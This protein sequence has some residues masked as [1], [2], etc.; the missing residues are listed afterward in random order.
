MWVWLYL[1]TTGCWHGKARVCLPRCL[2]NY[3]RCQVLEGLCEI[4]GAGATLCM[5][6][7]LCVQ[8]SSTGVTVP[9]CL[10][11]GIARPLCLWMLARLYATLW[12]VV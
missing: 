10:G 9:E 2:C 6:F 4:L 3:V 7:Q 5:H 1:Q 11:V 8:I 12:R